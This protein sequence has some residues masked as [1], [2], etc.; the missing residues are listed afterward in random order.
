MPQ[1]TCQARVKSGRWIASDARPLGEIHRT[2]CPER[3]A[4]S[5]ARKRDIMSWQKGWV[6]LGNWGRLHRG[7]RAGLGASEFV[8]W[9]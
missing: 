2:L 6:A 1:D 4:Q 8:W 3:G 5:T 7:Q 9:G